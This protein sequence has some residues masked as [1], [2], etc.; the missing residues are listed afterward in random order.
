MLTII[1]VGATAATATGVGAQ[2]HHTKTSNLIK[3]K[4]YTKTEDPPITRPKEHLKFKK[5]ELKVR[6]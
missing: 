5:R 6:K 3:Q 1:V 4:A 2:L